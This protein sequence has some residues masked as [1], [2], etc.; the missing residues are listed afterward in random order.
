ME[1]VLKVMKATCVVMK[2]DGEREESNIKR[3]KAARAVKNFSDSK[4]LG[5]DEMKYKMLKYENQS[6]ID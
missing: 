4:V 3:K 2:E 5:I 1:Y 6:K